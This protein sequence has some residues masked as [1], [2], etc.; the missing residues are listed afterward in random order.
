MKTALCDAL[1]RVPGMS[2]R[3][4]RDLYVSELEAYLGYSLS[5]KRNAAAHIDVRYVVNACLEH[6]NALR[7]LAFVLRG[8]HA[9]VTV[10]D[11]VDRSTEAAL[12]WLSGDRLVM[13]SPGEREALLRLVAAV[14]I[15]AVR[16]ATVRTGAVAGSGATRDV[17][18]MLIEVEEFATA[19][20][21]APLMLGF[22]DE[23]AHANSA[24]GGRD[25]HAWID[26][27]GD[28]LGVGPQSRREF[29]LSSRAVLALASDEAGTDE[30]NKGHAVK[31]DISEGDGSGD[32]TMPPLM[33]TP[34]G[35]RIWGGVPLRNPD[36]VGR[37]VLLDQLYRQLRKYTQ[38]SVLPQTL[39]GFGGVGK[40][41]LAVE[42]VYRHQAEYDV[43]WWIAAERPR[44]IRIDLQTLGTQIG[45]EGQTDNAEQ[46]ARNVINELGAGGRRWLLVYDNA[47]AP[48]TIKP[49]VPT[50]GGHVIIT[51]RDPAWARGGNALEVDVLEREESIDL[52]RRRDGDVSPED[53]DRL[54]EKLGDLP[55]AIEQ[56]AIWRNATGM[57]VDEY[58]ALLD[59]QVGEL[60]SEGQPA[61]YTTT[62]SAFVSLALERLHRDS[63]ATAELFELFAHLGP[64]PVSAT[65]LYN[66]RNATLSD[67]LRTALRDPIAMNR[68]IR[69]LVR[70]GLAKRTTTRPAHRPGEQESRTRPIQGIQVHRLI[71]RVLR[72][73]LDG[74][75]GE[76][77]RD[78]VRKLLAA[79]NPGLPDD[80]A[81]WP[82]HAEIGAHLSAADL[83]HSA[84]GDVR[85][86]VLDQ[87]RYLFRRGDHEASRSISELM[88]A[89]WS[90]PAD[91]GGLGKDHGDT[92]Q[93]NRHLANA[94]RVLGEH[95]RARQ[96][97]E[98]TM[99]RLLNNPEFGDDHEH[100]VAVAFGLGFDLS[101]AGDFAGSLV[102]DEENLQRARRRYGDEH[103]Y[104][105]QASNNVAASLRVLGQFRRAL[106]IDTELVRAWRSSAGDNDLRTLTAVGKLALDLYGLGRFEEALQTQ[107]QAFPSLQDL[108][109]GQHDQV[110]LAARTIAI[111]TRKVG[112]YAEALKLAREN[113]ELFRNRFGDTHENTLAAAMSYANALR[114]SGQYAEAR[115]VGRE[116]V[117]QYRSTFGPQHPHT[118]AAQ[119]NLGI[120]IRLLGERLEA[121]E[122]DG[123][124]LDTA[125]EVLGEE[126]PYTLCAASNYA[127]SL[128]L[129]HQLA[130]ARELS[131]H[132]YGL[133]LRVREDN[134][135]YTL[136][137][138][139]NLAFDR[140]ATGDEQGM[141][142]LLAVALGGLDAALGHEHPEA[143]D[144]H[145]GKR[146]DFDIEPPP[147]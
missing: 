49:L 11:E 133:S 87:A 46:A 89:E 9:N 34:T 37:D 120:I 76:R 146:A 129:G 145:R 5:T 65:M 104:T 122:L 90:R 66:G 83:I 113:R 41:Q 24:A 131:E 124:T 100:T 141:R 44:D 54:A 53:A 71:Q 138:A 48:E 99:E 57:S 128:V 27:V 137:S 10:M 21:A 26:G 92:L 64:D 63:P 85:Q 93:A 28:R 61:D 2:D 140:Q 101:I 127:S 88:C 73:T 98:D 1:L 118:I 7:G 86:T 72:G 58:I 147:T 116:T 18:R 62:L 70:L 111:A 132:T 117:D 81:T 109:G 75:A 67:T 40:T 125:R 94:L 130:K 55:L 45:V 74:T 134:H 47:E 91:Q 78:N 22:V 126:H 56:A 112:R 33:L 107:Q 136:G 59:Q 119:V 102:R 96:I 121:A 123:S 144:A 13:L 32:E 115:T 39:H 69:E 108:L 52:L 23:L 103:D 51:S 36:F 135:P 97:D 82:T 95:G 42:Y 139:L 77:S 12:R 38:A 15:A 84:D 29:C 19:N 16:S 14:P 17:Q 8:F 3:D 68:M 35:R 31:S 20:S 50:A 105:Y 106:E 60:M 79:S 143:V 80:P 43:I 6:P 142:E 4:A 114:V 25:L 30:D 110:L